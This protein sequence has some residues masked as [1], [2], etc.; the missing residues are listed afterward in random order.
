[1]CCKLLWPTCST[2][3]ACKGRPNQVGETTGMVLGE[4]TFDVP[5]RLLGGRGEGRARARGDCIQSKG[6]NESKSLLN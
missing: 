2:A 5:N 3:T 6:C 1:M 4:V